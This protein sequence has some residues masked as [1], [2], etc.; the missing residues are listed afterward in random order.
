[1]PAQPRPNPLIAA[2]LRRQLEVRRLFSAR[3]GDGAEAEDVAQE[4]YLKIAAVRDPDTIVDPDAYVFRLAYNL[5]S[6]RRRAAT[7]RRAREN[8]WGA[9]GASFCD[10]APV[11]LAP[12]ADDAVSARQELAVLFKTL[13]RLPARSREVFRLHKLDGLAHADV[14]RRLNV[15]VSA[16][17]KHMIRALAE[18]A[19]ALDR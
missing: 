2:Y 16:V 18:L 7:R 1:M 8:R 6:D 13:E 5:A 9:E 12:A 15:S 3:S 19:K 4:L 11:A 14:A 10:G 17:E